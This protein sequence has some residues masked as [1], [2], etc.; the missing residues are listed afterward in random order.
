ME[1]TIQELH[2][3][4][5]AKKID[6]SK[7]EINVTTRRGYKRIWNVAITSRDSSSITVYLEN[8]YT[9]TGNLGHNLY[10]YP[11]KWITIRKLKNNDTILTD[12]GYS[13]V[14]SKVKND[15]KQDLY[16]LE[17]DDINEYYTNGVVS[18]NSTISQSIKLGLYGKLKEITLKEVPNR[19]NKNGEIYLN[20]SANG[21]KIKIIRKFEPSNFELYVDNKIIDLSSKKETQSFLEDD[22]LDMPY[23]VFDNMISLSLNDFKS[24]ISMSPSDKRNIIDKVFSLHI[25]NAMRDDVKKKKS[26]LQRVIDKSES[27][28]S[29]VTSNIESTEN[30]IKE[31]TK[32]LKLKQD[33][34][35]YEYK[36]QLEKIN[37]KI[38]TLNEKMER[39][40]QIFNK[41]EK[42]VS[43]KKDEIQILNFKI[44]NINR[45]LKLY[46]N[47][48]CPT[49][50]SDLTVEN[51]IQNKK[52]YEN[53]LDELKNK[54]KDLK[55]EYVKLSDSFN[56]IKDKLILIR[57]NKSK[58]NGIK[59]EIN[60]KILNESKQ[61][62]NTDTIESFQK[63]IT[64]NEEKRKELES[65]IKKSLQKNKFYSV[66]EDI[67]S[68]DGI[69]KNIIASI[70]PNLNNS[71][72]SF[73]DKFNMPFN[74]EFNE[75]F[76]TKIK[77]YGDT[78]TSGSLSLG[79][80][81]I[82]DICILLSMIKILKYKYG[83]LNVLFLDE[84]FASISDKNRL[85]IIKILKEF[86]KE[87][88]LNIFVINHSPLPIEYF[89]N[90]IEVEKTNRFSNLT[91]VK[92]F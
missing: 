68:E 6:L 19:V 41:K 23:Y 10:K 85:I 76:K 66:S 61:N 74:I 82:L 62:D 4:I 17:V 16:D 30:K 86:S 43:D 5:K 40:Q 13:T 44:Q 78:I 51:H 24:F 75:K 29:Y 73:L 46:E 69:K 8:G 80:S 59:S 7:T 70:I 77:S 25:L 87:F 45:D 91:Y 42:L 1:C 53:E 3:F 27:A 2:D 20:L 47:S 11:D 15:F 9:I 90:M 84:I 63:I 56:D 14:V 34:K 72:N 36:N 52:N 39:A 81:K 12:Q 83:N 35:I 65:T 18:H 48:K 31:L 88:A 60:S 64:E 22:F 32:K 33:S 79:E 58:L 92:E 57:D 50:K 71:I 55:T 89:D 28:L 26:E 54:L 67:L 49:C 37:Q 21:K 38:D